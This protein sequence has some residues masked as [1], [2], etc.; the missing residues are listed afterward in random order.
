MERT[1]SEVPTRPTATAILAL[2][3]GGHQLLPGQDA[4][5][6]IADPIERDDGAALLDRLAALLESSGHVLAIHPRW[7]APSARLRLEM[8]D[9]ILDRPRFA[10]HETALPPLAAEVLAALAAALV[11]HI[12]APGLLHALLPRIEAELAWFAWLGSVKGL[13]EPSPSVIQHA[14]SWVPGSDFGVS[15]W[16]EP[17]VRRLTRSDRGV[18]VPGLERPSALVVAA[19]DERST[20]VAETL[21]PALGLAPRDLGP[22]AGGRAWWGTERLVEAVVH[23]ADPEELATRVA[24]A[25]PWWICRWC[26]EVAAAEPC[27]FCGLVEG[28][29]GAGE[30]A[31]G[32]PGAGSGA[33]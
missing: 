26:G 30:S 8:T 19:R 4:V 9:V 17:S 27:P 21:A 12:A 15:S 1:V 33:A 6:T 32:A 7:F 11:P 10:L 3:L 16:P 23:P 20:W 25:L 28:R 14:S 5:E 24:T 2:G 22:T 18:P 31:P 13:R 29:N